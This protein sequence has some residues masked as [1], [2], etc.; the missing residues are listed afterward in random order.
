MF[1]GAWVNQGT[2]NADVGNATISF[3]STAGNSFTNNGTFEAQNGGTLSFASANVTNYA[4][5]N[6]TLTGGTWEAFA[7]SIVR[8][9]TGGIT[10]D[11]ATILLDS[12]SSHIY[13][14]PNGTNM[15]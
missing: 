13:T 9:F 6:G 11:A 8:G 10:T 4:L 15:P 3:D 5:V 2:I 1:T 12:A 14:G 7:N